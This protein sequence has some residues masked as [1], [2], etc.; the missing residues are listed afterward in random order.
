MKPP[1]VDEEFCKH[2][3]HPAISRVRLRK[4]FSEYAFVT[5]SLSGEDFYTLSEHVTPVGFKVKPFS[6]DE[7]TIIGAYTEHYNEM[8]DAKPRAFPV[9][10]ESEGF[11]TA[12]A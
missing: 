8:N 4:F 9:G 11:P 1:S 2:L 5:V 10:I 3:K 7:L 12:V 6:P